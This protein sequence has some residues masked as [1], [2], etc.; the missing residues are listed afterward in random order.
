[1]GIISIH[2]CKGSIIKVSLTATSG[3]NY[4]D[5]KH[6]H[7]V[8]LLIQKEPLKVVIRDR[9]FAQKAKRA[10][11]HRKQHEGS[12][13]LAMNVIIFCVSELFG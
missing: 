7:S 12:P 13:F 9:S 6:S 1:M 10:V 4:Q 11:K 3:S 2:L 8:K 5:R